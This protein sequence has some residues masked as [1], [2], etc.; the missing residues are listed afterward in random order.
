MLAH[1]PGPLRVVASWCRQPLRPLRRKHGRFLGA[2]TSRQR[3]L[4]SVAALDTTHKLCSRIFTGPNHMG[5]ILAAGGFHLYEAMCHEL[6]LYTDI[7]T[8]SDGP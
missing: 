5:V 4:T 8:A 1:P 2:A 7:I 6:P 3:S